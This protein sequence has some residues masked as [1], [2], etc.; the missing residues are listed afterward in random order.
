MKRLLLLMMFSS[1]GCVPGG[2]RVGGGILYPLGQP[3]VV[4]VSNNKLQTGDLYRDNV[5]VTTLPTGGTVSVPLTYDQLKN[6][7]VTFKAFTPSPSGEKFYYGQ[8][9]RI[10]KSQSGSNENQEWTVD[11]VQVPR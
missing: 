5:F 1:F 11:Y 7:V 3:Q 10:F 4:F 8:V 2:F 9:T 6:V